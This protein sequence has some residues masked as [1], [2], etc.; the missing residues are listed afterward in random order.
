M[1]NFSLSTQLF[2]LFMQR[3][4]PAISA[5][6]FKLKLIRFCP[7]ILGGR[8]ISSFALCALKSNIDFHLKHPAAS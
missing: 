5:K 7:F 8:I 3:M 6:F 4:S 2:R 1:I